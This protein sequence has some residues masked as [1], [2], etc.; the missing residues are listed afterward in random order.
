MKLNARKQKEVTE[1][2]W[3]NISFIYSLIHLFIQLFNKYV[4][5]V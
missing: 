5:V 4:T 3:K 2:S 1:K